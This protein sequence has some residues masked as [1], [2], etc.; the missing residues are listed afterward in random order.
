[1]HVTADGLFDDHNTRLTVCL[2]LRHL[3]VLRLPSLVYMMHVSAHGETWAA[4]QHNEFCE[5]TYSVCGRTN[6]C[7]RE[8]P[9]IQVFDRFFQHIPLEKT[10]VEEY[11][12][13]HE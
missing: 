6:S 11:S 8:F 1:M 5:K 13:G 10:P 12:H 7:L 9:D 4:N 3:S 2:I